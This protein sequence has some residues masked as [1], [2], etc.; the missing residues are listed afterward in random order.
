MGLEKTK[1]ITKIIAAKKSQSQKQ[2]QTQNVIVNVN[3]SR[4][5]R[6]RPIKKPPQSAPK[7]YFQ[8]PIYMPPVVTYNQ[9]MRDT[10]SIISNILKIINKPKPENN[11]LEKAKPVEREPVV[12]AP[13]LPSVFETPL[14]SESE[15]I[16]E[17]PPSPTLPSVFETPLQSESE[18]IFETP[19]KSESKQI[20]S[21]QTLP[22]IFGIPQQRI[23][24]VSEIKSD[25]MNTRQTFI[26][27]PPFEAKQEP[28]VFEAPLKS[29]SEFIFKEPFVFEQPLKSESEFIFKEPS[30]VQKI[31]AE[32]IYAGLTP[33]NVPSAIQEKKF[34]PETKQ[35]W[36]ELEL[37]GHFGLLGINT[38]DLNKYKDLHKQYTLA[39]A[40]EP[41]A[42]TLVEEERPTGAEID[43]GIVPPEAQEMVQEDEPPIAHIL[44][45]E[46][47]PETLVPEKIAT[48]ANTEQMQLKALTMGE[49]K[50]FLKSFLHSTP[51]PPLKTIPFSKDELELMRQSRIKAVDKKPLLL[52]QTAEPII[53]PETNQPVSAEK[54]VEKEED[55]EL[56]ILKKISNRNLGVI[57]TELGGHKSKYGGGTKTKQ[58]L[59]E[60]ILELRKT[61]PALFEQLL[62][63]Y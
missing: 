42:P 11:E 43:L 48:K 58:M 26:N 59:A 41:T 61:Q 25:P 52:T 57:I 32:D 1:K 34:E 12:L 40:T 51:L 37:G 46:A 6:K 28:F 50:P 27:T 13:T 14:Q 4:A 33:S 9:P 38:A 5:P 39:E 21:T 56:Q 15:F 8:S 62:S 24:L 3:A 60:G 10:D 54:E 55:P 16:F 23:S 47:K 7:T 35:P 45:E 2:K 63:K 44:V 19:L 36:A 17:T 29:E 18:F 53:N 22:S 20:S 49:E 30:L 31:R